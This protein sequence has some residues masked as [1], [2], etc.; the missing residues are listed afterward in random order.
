M[1]VTPEF[2]GQVYKDTSNG[3]IWRAN[4]TTPG[5]WTLEVQNIW[6]SSGDNPAEQLGCFSYYPIVGATTI[7][8]NPTQNLNG[9]DVGDLTGVVNFLCPNLVN[10]GAGG[11]TGYFQ[12]YGWSNLTTASFPLLE[13]VLGS[14]SIDANALSSID[15]AS[16]QTVQTV[17]GG[18][19]LSLSNTTLATL[20]LPVFTGTK[21]TLFSNGSLTSFSAPNFASGPIEVSSPLLTTFTL[22]AY[23]PAN[24]VDI[25]FNGCA[26]TQAKVDEILAKAVANAGYVSGTIDLQG[27]TNS[28]PSGAGAANKAILIGRGV[29]VLTN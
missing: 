25:N 15:L 6:T 3:N 4:S 17:G 1:P 29:T 10:I 26:L 24:G 5:D 18:N 14:F 12:I 20:S 13:T 28:A 21:L 22:T 11:V 9:F 8:Y 2:V 16:L 7:Q 23:S 27:G 19:G